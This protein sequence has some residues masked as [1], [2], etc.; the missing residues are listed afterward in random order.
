VDSADAVQAFSADPQ[1]Q[2]FFG[3]MFEGM[4]EVTIDEGSRWNEW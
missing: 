2:E 3:Q 4:P 1:I